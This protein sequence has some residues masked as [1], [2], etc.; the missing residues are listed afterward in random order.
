[1]TTAMHDQALAAFEE[2]G[3]ISTAAGD[4]RIPRIPYSSRVLW[5]WFRGLPEG[6]IV[7]PA[8][9]PRGP[10]L[11]HDWTSC[12]HLPTPQLCFG[13]ASLP[14]HLMCSSCWLTAAERSQDA[15]DWCGSKPSANTTVWPA[16][17]PIGPALVLLMLCD[18][19]IV[20]GTDQMC[21]CNDEL[22]KYVR[23]TL[24]SHS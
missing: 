13:M 20:A 14:G 4:A 22:G 7:A 11:E 16:V 15:C 5:T 24:K 6:E 2:A 3:R 18:S 12:G 17:Y 10:V 9:R 23:H 19:H 21:T 1:M 8:T